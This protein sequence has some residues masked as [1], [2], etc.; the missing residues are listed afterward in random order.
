MLIFEVEEVFCSSDVK[1]H[2]QP[3]GIILANT[4]ELANRAAEFVEV[5]YDGKP[6]KKVVATL[7]D[8]EKSSPRITPVLQFCQK[9]EQIGDL[10]GTKHLSGRLETGSQY[11]YTMEPQTCVAFPIEDGIEVYSASQYID[12][13]QM[14]IAEC[15]KLPNNNV[16]MSVRRLGGGYGAK[17]TRNI[18]IAC[19][20]AL[21]AHLLNRPVRFIMTIEANMT[22]VGKRVSCIGDYDVHFDKNGRIQKLVCDYV[23][24][25]G[26]SSNEPSK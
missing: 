25:S 18:Q 20:T 5:K 21:A 9:A 12:A 4:S 13:A 23:E 15:L 17:I 24:D 26:C 14:A 8:V 22:V 19:A 16:N 10:A 2:G 3:V 11:H 7:Q 6:T 1:F